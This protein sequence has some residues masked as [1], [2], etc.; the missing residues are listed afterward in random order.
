[1][2]YL[3]LKF[4]YVHYSHTKLFN[5]LQPKEY[6]NKLILGAQNMFKNIQKN[7]RMRNCRKFSIWMHQIKRIIKVQKIGRIT[8]I[9]DWG[10]R[11]ESILLERCSLKRHA[12]RYRYRPFLFPVIGHYRFQNIGSD[13]DGMGFKLT[14]VFLERISIVFILSCDD[15][16]N[17]QMHL[18]GWPTYYVFHTMIKFETIKQ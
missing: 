1:M 7:I 5:L 14:D 6:S 18:F 9:Y 4:K 17:M 16:K 15:E 13:R 3:A 8:F 2:Q 11:T 12:I 10:L